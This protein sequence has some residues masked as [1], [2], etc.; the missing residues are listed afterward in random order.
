MPKPATDAIHLGEGVDPAAN[1]LTLPIYETTTY[2]FDKA[3]DLLAYQQG[4]S[5][6]FIYSRY[7]NPTVLG[8][9]KKLAAIEGGETALLLS[10]GMAAVTTAVLS[11]TRAGGEVVCGSA[12]YGGTLHLLA[13][14]LS[15]FGIDARFVEP[16][17]MTDPSTYSDRTRLAWFES[18]INPTLRCVDIAAVAAACRARGVTSVIDSTFG[19]PVNQR[20]LDLGVDIV[21]HSATKYLNGHG[22]ITAGVLVGSAAA[23]KECAYARKMLGT[24]LDPAAAYAVGRGLKTLSARMAVHNAN[25]LRLAE[26]LE[27]SG[28]VSRVYYPGLASHPDHAIAKRQMP[29]G[30]SGMICIDLDGDYARAERFY[31]RLQIF[32]RAASLG[33]TESLCSLPILTSQWGH[34]DDQLAAAGVTRGMARLSVGLED[35]EDLAAD[36]QQA[37]A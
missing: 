10:S 17:A 19:T 1:P 7:A 29:G 4:K 14:L 25:A 36:L 23:M 35:F 15:R 16:E 6:Q 9:E 3:A 30:F 37:L 21:M 32:K 31:D 27:Q 11:V 24:V 22:D 2:V 18:P 28:K 34:T 12:V 26:W 13:D 33:G 20:P 8:V 5:D